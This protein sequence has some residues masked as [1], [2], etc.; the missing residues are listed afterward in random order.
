MSR[1]EFTFKLLDTI[2]SAVLV[3]GILLAWQAF[4]GDQDQRRRAYTMHLYDQWRALLDAGDV[5][6]TLE[7]V[8]DNRLSDQNLRILL[9]NDENA[10]ITISDQ[11]YTYEDILEMRNHIV[12]ILNFFEQV[13]VSRRDHVGDQ[14]MIDAYLGA[15]IMGH[16][17][18]LAPFTDAWE[19]AKARRGWLPL[20][21][22]ATT[23]WSDQLQP[24]LPPVGQR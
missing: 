6:P 10:T 24:A 9:T 2:L 5:R 21:D 11:T 22:A 20:D 19:T 15:A 17:R 8:R 14:A 18:A 1:T 16:Y 7:M 12:A 23:Y 3:I 13:A 4:R